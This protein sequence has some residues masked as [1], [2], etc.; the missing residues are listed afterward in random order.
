MNKTR[1]KKRFKLKQNS[2]NSFAFIRWLNK[3]GGASVFWRPQVFYGVNLYF[4][5]SPRETRARFMRHF[6]GMRPL[7]KATLKN[8]DRSPSF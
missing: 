8:T 3:D 5:R 4:T 6:P 7:C 2:L 1:S